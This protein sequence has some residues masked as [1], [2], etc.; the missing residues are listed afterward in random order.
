MEGKLFV[1]YENFPEMIRHAQGKNTLE[2][3]FMM[4]ELAKLSDRCAFYI[5]Q[6]IVDSIIIRLKEFGE[7]EALLEKWRDDAKSVFNA[8]NPDIETLSDADLKRYNPRYLYIYMWLNYDVETPKFQELGKMF[9]EIFGSSLVSK[10][11]ESLFWL[12]GKSLT[13][14]ESVSEK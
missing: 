4:M 13:I 10:W 1:K 6:A 9:A 5:K 11:K 3:L 12:V 8:A 7:D 14:N 2:M